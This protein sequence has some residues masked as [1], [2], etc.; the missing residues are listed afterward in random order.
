[1]TIPTSVTPMKE[2]KLMD[3][4]ERNL[5]IG[6]IADQ[7]EAEG[8]SP[9]LTRLIRPRGTVEVVLVE[10]RNEYKLAEEDFA[11]IIACETSG[12]TGSIPESDDVDLAR[13]FITIVNHQ[14]RHVIGREGFKRR[15]THTLDDIVQEAWARE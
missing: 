5:R 9:E 13:L 3:D 4:P 1:M 11:Q 8:V 6:K 2:R 10:E 15:I 7:L 12:L 14:A